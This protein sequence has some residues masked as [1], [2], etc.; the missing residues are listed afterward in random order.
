ML[1]GA[2]AVTRT[3]LSGARS[4]RVDWKARERRA[5]EGGLRELDARAERLAA[6]HDFGERCAGGDG[7][8]QVHV[9]VDLRE[10][11]VAGGQHTIGEVDDASGV[12]VQPEHEDQSAYSIAQPQREVGIAA[13]TQPVRTG[14]LSRTLSQNVVQRRLARVHSHHRY[15]L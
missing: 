14:E 2:A 10:L 11:A 8:G 13:A 3:R 4:R 6:A 5:I 1:T 7:V 15:V 9:D 12:N